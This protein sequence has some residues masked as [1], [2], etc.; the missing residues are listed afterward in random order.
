MSNAFYSLWPKFKVGDRIRVIN[1]ED[2]MMRICYPFLI[3]L[4]GKVLSFSN[5]DTCDGSYCYITDIITVL[6]CHTPFNEAYL[7][8]ASNMSQLEQDKCL[9]YKKSNMCNKYCEMLQEG[10]CQE[11]IDE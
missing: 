9:R 10:K 4:E 2:D 5:G 7:E 3:G 1:N 6:D 8:L 11:D